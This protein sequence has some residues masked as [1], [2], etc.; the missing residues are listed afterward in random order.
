MKPKTVILLVV[1][2]LVALVPA[3]VMAKGQAK[4]QKMGMVT[5]DIRQPIGPQLDAQIGV[6][7][8][9]PRDVNAPSAWGPRN[10]SN[11][12]Q[13]NAVYALLNTGFEAPE[14]PSTSGNADGFDFAEL[15]AS[16]VGWDSTY[17]KA[18][19][20]QQ[21]L[22]SAGYLNDPFF[23]PYYDNDM[24]SYAFYGMDLQGAR[25]VNARFQYLSDT[26][27]GYDYFYWCSSDDGFT[28]LC[29]YHTGSTNNTWRLVN[30]DSRSSPIMSDLLD[31]PFAYFGFIFESDFIIVDRGTFVDAMRIRAW[32][33]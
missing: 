7:S 20:G 3:L 23:N 16:P 18:K 22:Y 29:Q 33:P 10:S 27:Y 9:G 12:I 1:L 30:L 2:L 11:G 19:R 13:P 28:F 17:Y 26:E 21:S 4:P 24:E 8:R 6:S 32:G 5:I 14:W 25:R 31:E 15:G